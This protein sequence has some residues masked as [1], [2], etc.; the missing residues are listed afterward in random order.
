MAKGIRILVVATMVLMAW[1]ALGGVGHASTLP[2]AC[3][4]KITGAGEKWRRKSIS[5]AACAP[6][7]E[8][9]MINGRLIKSGSAVNS[10]VFV[11]CDGRKISL[12]VKRL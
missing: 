2:Q 8:K 9:E 12:R 11:A 7:P 4:G 5:R 1:L 10:T 3:G 6:S